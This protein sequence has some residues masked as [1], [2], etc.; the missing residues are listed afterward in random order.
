MSHPAVPLALGCVIGRAR[1]PV[2]FWLLGAAVSIVPDGDVIS[3][4]LRIPYSAPFGHRGAT[5]SIVFAA[6]LAALLTL[7]FWRRLPTHALLFVFL[8]LS[9]L[10]HALLDMLTDGGLGVA[11]LWPFSD[12]RLFFPVTPI[13]VSPIGAA[14]FS[15][16]GRTVIS[17]ELF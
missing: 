12:A 1:L 3:F 4:V 13:A 16:A 14:F 2:R 6:G 10:S 9:T 15:P 5:H 17:S 7:R 8:F 11:L